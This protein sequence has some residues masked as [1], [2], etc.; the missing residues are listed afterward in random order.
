MIDLDEIFLNILKILRIRLKF[1]LFY[2]INQITPGHRITPGHLTDLESRKAH[3]TI[4][5]MKI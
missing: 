1:I 3:L 5:K 2:C 4:G